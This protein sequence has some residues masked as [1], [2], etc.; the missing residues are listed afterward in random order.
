MRNG[1]GWLGR[2]LLLLAVMGCSHGS[3]AGREEPPGSW[4]TE[5]TG[6]RTKG[7]ADSATLH[8]EALIAQGQFQAAEAYL[9][10]AIAAGLVAREAA[11]RLRE[12]IAERKQQQNS[13]Q[14]RR[15]PPIKLKDWEIEEAPRRTCATEMPDYP[16]CRALPEEYSFHSPRQALEAMKQRLGQK[17][18]ALHG[19]EQADQGPCPDVGRHYNVRLNGKRSGSITC[20][21]CCVGDESSPVLWTKC[22]IVW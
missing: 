11:T 8:I 6:I 14:D 21:R 17:N 20:C 19:E 12:K 1:R 2:V 10:N 9:V 16:V 22:R 5:D 3:S 18:L 4:A 15:V 13:E 7:G